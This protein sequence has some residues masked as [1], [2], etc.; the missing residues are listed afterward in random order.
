MALSVAVRVLEQTLRLLHPIMPFIT[1]ELWQRLP[2]QGETIMYAPW[3]EPEPSLEDE[4]VLA[5]MAHLLDVVQKIRNTRQESAAGV[6][7]ARA[8]LTSTHPLLGQ[9]VGQR[10]VATLA[11]LDLDGAGT[12]KADRKIV[13][14]ETQVAIELPQATGP[15]ERARLTRELEQ[16]EREIEGLRQKLQNPGFASKAPKDVIQKERA[17]LA[18][19]EAAA[20]RLR[21]LLDELR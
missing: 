1:E 14:G 12:L 13:V 7:R 17:R 20:E 8:S 21:R 15:Q 3:P 16:K 5:E 2:H 4:G 19:A 11:G 6:G 10:Y 9:P 18:R